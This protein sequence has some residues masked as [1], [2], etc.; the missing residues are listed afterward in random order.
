MTSALLTVDD[1]RTSYFTEDGEVRSVDGV[2]LRLQ[3]GEVLGLVGESGSGKSVMGLSLMGLI[4]SPGKVAGGSIRLDGVEL[5]GAL[6]RDLR[7]IR[8]RKIG[9]IFQD[10]LM[11]LN[12]VLRIGTTLME[13]VT[14]HES[15]G[16][17]VAR[18]RA[19]AALASVGIPSPL[20]RMRAYPHEMSGGMRQRVAIAAALLP[21]PQLLIADE[22]TTALD[23]TI[24]S[25]ILH[26]L[27]D[28]VATRGLALIMVSHDLGVVA[29]LADRVAVMY[30]GRI[31]ESG[32]VQEILAAPAHPY[33][34]GLIRSA[35]VLAQPGT[36]LPQIPGTPP[37][38]L[39]RPPG[40]AFAPRCERAD[41]QCAAMPALVDLPQRHAVRCWHPYPEPVA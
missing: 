13:S 38:P 18:E 11:A 19:V 33:T 1:L 25:Q 26:L 23:V 34:R 10:P 41:A 28:L 14:A 5:V 21:G 29:S 32:P 40:C 37:S 2:S 7:G 9:M 6:E 8:G 39:E 20:E 27:Q 35:P 24:Q 30:A 4:D 36:A 31:V 16:A 17:D 12:P 15:V 22:P 3:R